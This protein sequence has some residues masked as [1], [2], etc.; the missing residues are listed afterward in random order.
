MPYIMKSIEKDIDIHGFFSVFEGF[1]PIDFN[2]NGE[3][4]DF[5]EMVFVIDG[6]IGVAADEQVYTL[7]ANEI[8][9]HKPMEL[10][11]L[12]SC[13]DKKPRLLTLSFNASG[14][15]LKSLERGVFHLTPEQKSKLFSLIGY[16]RQSFEYSSEKMINN[17]LKCMCSPH[18]IQT[19]SNLLELFLLSLGNEG[20][21]PLDNLNDRESSVYKAA[22][23]VMDELIFEN[24]SVS[25]IADKC[26]VSASYL[27]KLFAKY[28]GMG[29]HKYFLRLKLN[30]AAALLKQGH[31]VTEVSEKLAFNTQNYFSTVFKRELGEVPSSYAS[32]FK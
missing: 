8:I 21:V 1:Y 27:K 6:K 26:L 7:S 15:I 28:A 14:D 5:W 11:R 12:W 23:R 18:H 29:V 25:D 22:V 2:F 19:I 4:H 17:F 30:C 3:H 32:R 31:S 10:H 16:M 20:G 24:P 13:G 9:F